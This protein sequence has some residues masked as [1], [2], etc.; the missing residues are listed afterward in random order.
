MGQRCK[1]RK[2]RGVVTGMTVVMVVAVRRK[3]YI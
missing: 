3:R 1:E 2:N